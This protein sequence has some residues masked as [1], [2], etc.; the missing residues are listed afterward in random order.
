MTMQVVRLQPAR[1]GLVVRGPDGA[2]LPA[3]GLLVTLTTFWARR[4]RDGDV[5]V[6]DAPAGAAP[7][8]RAEG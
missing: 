4:L 7:K 1:P 6:A 5:V 8:K 3:E 2:P